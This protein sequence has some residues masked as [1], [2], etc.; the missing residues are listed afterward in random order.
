M[1]SQQGHHQENLRST[2]SVFNRL[3]G[4]QTMASTNQ[5]F[6]EKR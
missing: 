5:H 6:E 1:Y 3:H 4:T 2:S